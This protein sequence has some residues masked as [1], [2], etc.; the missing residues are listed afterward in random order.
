[1]YRMAISDQYRTLSF[2]HDTVPE[3][4]TPGDPL[5][6]DLDADVAIVGAGFTGLWT[7]YYLARRC[8]RH[9][10]RSLPG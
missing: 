9:R 4:L 1:M 3:A 5:S 10:W 6:G 2:W 8:S 7:A